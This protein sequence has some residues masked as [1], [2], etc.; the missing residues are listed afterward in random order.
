M[1]VNYNGSNMDYVVDNQMRS[2]LKFLNNIVENGYHL[3]YF[4]DLKSNVISKR[5]YAY[6]KDIA[7][8]KRSNEYNLNEELIRHYGIARNIDN[9][10]LRKY[11]FEPEDL[12]N[13]FIGKKSRIDYMLISN[14]KGIDINKDRPRDEDRR[15]DLI[16]NEREC[17]IFDTLIERRQSRRMRDLNNRK[18]GWSEEYKEELL[19]NY[20]VYRNVFY[21]V[22]IFLRDTK[23]FFNFENYQLKDIKLLKQENYNDFKAGRD[24]KAVRTMKFRICK[25][26]LAIMES[27]NVDMN[28]KDLCKYLVYLTMYFHVLG[29]EDYMLITKLKDYPN[30]NYW[31]IGS[32][33][34]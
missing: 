3:K 11:N 18:E 30:I 6:L 32:E 33:I 31:L 27:F 25:Q 23:F 2:E 8:G 16:F 13:E 12:N 15:I 9:K 1:I 24:R 4:N 14:E 21:E 28:E 34:M 29:D 20:S 19:N 10:F 17:E 5:T 26:T 7:K 22:A